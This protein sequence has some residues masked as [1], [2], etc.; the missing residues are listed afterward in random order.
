MTN[1]IGGTVRRQ[2]MKLLP[3]LRRLA[4]VLANSAEEREELLSAACEAMLENPHRYQAGTPIEQWAFAEIHAMWLKR[5][6][7]RADPIAQ[8]PAEERLFLPLTAEMDG[9][10]EFAV[11]LKSLAA[12]QRV[13]MLLVYGEG[14]SYEE[15]AKILDTPLETVAQ[16]ATR[17]LVAFC[18]HLNGETPPQQRDADI[19]PL[20]P[21]PKRAPA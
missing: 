7:E 5:L 19:Q 3:R 21:E 13:V 14:Y 4:G 9:D 15:T 18:A 8:G 1:A 11:F 20:Y 17:G 16:R 10:R 12:Q 6:R 2:L